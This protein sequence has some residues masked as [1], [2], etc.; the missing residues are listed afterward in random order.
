MRWA[1]ALGLL[2]GCGATRMPSP[3]PS[4]R[5]Y[6]DAIARGEVHAAYA[7][8]AAKVRA[9]ISEPDFAA[10]FADTA[11]ERRARAESIRAALA[12]P[13]QTPIVSAQIENQGRAA[14]LVRDPNGWRLRQ[15]RRTEVGAGSP[16]EALA[17]L[18]RALDGHDLDAILGLC[19]PPLRAA[20]ERALAE[21]LAGLR[22]LVGRAIVHAPD[23]TVLSY[24][25]GH[26]ID[27]VKENGTWRIADFN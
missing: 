23:R 4:L 9:R 17:R 6:A 27:F 22:P 13:A 10:R 18:V 16:E 12:P 15:P 20:L 14:D 26:H 11:E 19:A 7:M 3:A 24:G 2:A 1:L 8:L 5:A 25:D 21:R